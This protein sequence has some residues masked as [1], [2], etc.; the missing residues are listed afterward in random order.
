MPGSKVVLITGAASGF[1]GG[2]GN[3][4]SAMGKAQRRE[5]DRLVNELRFK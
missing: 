5:L 2:H 4:Q 3:L 1:G